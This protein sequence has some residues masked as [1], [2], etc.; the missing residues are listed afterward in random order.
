MLGLD[1]NPGRHLGKPSRLGEETSGKERSSKT[2]E[3]PSIIF[4]AMD[5]DKTLGPENL[6]APAFAPFEVVLDT[7]AALDWLVFGDPAM[8]AVA[9]RIEE[10]SCR[11]VGTLATLGELAIVCSRPELSRWADALPHAVAMAH[12]HCQRVEAPEVP[13]ARRLHCTDPDD[14]KFIDLAIGRPTVRCLVTRD[15]ALLKLARKAGA[16]NLRV[17]RPCDW[18][19]TA[20]MVG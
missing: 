18:P 19:S 2:A 4:R 7:N 11:W 20:L 16:R 8:L 5:V 9:A 3:K 13:R 10:G 14:Q 17:L 12:A 1:A 6:G 15:K